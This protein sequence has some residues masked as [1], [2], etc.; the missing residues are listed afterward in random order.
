MKKQY[1][2]YN[3]ILKLVDLKIIER[4]LDPTDINHRE[5]LDSLFTQYPQI[6]V[7]STRES[8]YIAVEEKNTLIKITLKYKILE[9]IKCE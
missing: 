7:F 5:D 1:E 2:I 4:E 8:Y 9:L 6:A 3:E